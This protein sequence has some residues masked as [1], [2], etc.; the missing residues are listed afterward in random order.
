VLNA[1][2]FRLQLYWLLTQMAMLRALIRLNGD[3]RRSAD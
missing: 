2:S 3:P 1:L